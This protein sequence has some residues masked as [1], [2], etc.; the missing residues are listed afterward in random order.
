MSRPDMFQLKMREKIYELIERPGILLATLGV[1]VTL[2]VG[3]FG[4]KQFRSYQL[5]NR[6]D[7]ISTIDMAYQKAQQNFQETASSL[8][9]EQMTTA[10][11]IADLK[12]KAKL[13]D[14]DSKE[15]A[16]LE[17][18]LNDRQ[19]KIETMRLE[20]VKGFDE[21]Y[22]Q[23]FRDYPNSKEG[24]RAAVYAASLAAERKDFAAATKTLE[25]AM[26]YVS[27]DTLFYNK[28]KEF[29]INIL[30]ESKNH[31]KAISE[32]DKLIAEKSKSDKAPLL[33]MKGQMLLALEKKT[34]A[35]KVFSDIIAQHSGS[36][37]ELKAKALKAL[38]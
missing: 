10:R 13:S 28:I 2:V 15:L 25:E 7:A 4:L 17:Q 18:E 32:L 34:E 20:A 37:E 35:G 8:N 24:N 12:G 19:Q 16:K 11:K 14:K 22:L 27:K 33:L 3:Y 36:E 26:K 9:R 1:I 30:S 21:K 29:Y 38:L 31:D 6:T 5:N 23:F